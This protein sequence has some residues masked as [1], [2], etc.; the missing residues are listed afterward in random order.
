MQLSAHFALIEFEKHG[1]L[2]PKFVPFLAE[3]CGSI[4]EPIRLKFGALAV[5][6]GNRSAA[7]NAATG[8]V[9]NSEHVYTDAQCAADFVSATGAELQAIFDWIRMESGLDFDQVILEADKEIGAPSCIHVGSRA[10]P[11]RMAL[12]GQ[13]HGT[14]AYREVEVGPVTQEAA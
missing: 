5:T 14:G 13:T 6:S 12:V 4:L 10:T 8:G 9:C 3:F 11:R 1:A 2:D 7:F